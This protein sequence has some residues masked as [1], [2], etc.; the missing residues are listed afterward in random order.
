MPEWDRFWSQALT[1]LIERKPIGAAM[2]CLLTR[3]VRPPLAFT[4]PEPP[5]WGRE[6]PSSEGNILVL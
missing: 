5:A 1:G 4:N 2:P 6:D 3:K